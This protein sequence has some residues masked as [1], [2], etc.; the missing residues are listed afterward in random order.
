MI[1]L[2]I[3]DRSDIGGPY[4]GSRVDGSHARAAASN[5]RAASCHHVNVAGPPSGTAAFAASTK[6]SRSVIASR[7]ASN[8][9]GVEIA[10]ANAAS[11]QPRWAIWSRTVQGSARVGSAHDAGGSPRTS[12][13]TAAR[14]SS[15]SASRSSTEGPLTRPAP[16][17]PRRPRS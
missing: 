2:V 11:N 7:S 3:A 14:S 12:A 8:S 1:R 16:T 13:I 5:A 9:A 15:R 4:Q 17:G 6:P 10:R